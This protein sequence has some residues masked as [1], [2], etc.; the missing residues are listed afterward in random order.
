VLVGVAQARVIELEAKYPGDWMLHCHLP[1][2]MMNQMFSM[3]GPMAHVGSGMHTG[4]GMEEGMGM[5][6]QGHALDEELGP[7]LGR[8]MGMT[9]REKPVSHMAGMEHTP[10]GMERE[11]KRVPGFP[12]D[13]WMT[14]D[15]V[16]KPET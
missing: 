14:M 6:R 1:H 3:L 12:Q 2:H 5:V 13:M 11:K 10:A 4:M 7:G 9:E 8:G 16:A 15:E